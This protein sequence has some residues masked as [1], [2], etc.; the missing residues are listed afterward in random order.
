MKRKVNLLILLVVAVLVLSLA[1]VACS[2]KIDRSKAPDDIGVTDP[3]ASVIEKASETDENL[4]LRFVF[5]KYMSSVFTAIPIDVFD[6]E[7]P[8]FNIGDFIKY[9]VIYSVSGAPFDNKLL[10]LK[11][12]DISEVDGVTVNQLDKLKV[13]GKHIVKVSIPRVDKDP[14]IGS[15]TLN[16]AARSSDIQFVKLSFNLN[17]GTAYFGNKSSNGRQVIELPN[18]SK[19]TWNDFIRTFLMKK[20]GYVID[21]IESTTGKKFDA[22]N[23]DINENPVVFDE[24]V[25]FNV[26]WTANIVNVTF[27]PKKPADA[28]D[29][30]PNADQVVASVT[31]P[32][33]VVMDKGTIERPDSE[34]VNSYYG[35]NFAGW[36]Y[37]DPDEGNAEKLWLFTQTVGRRD[38]ALYGKWVPRYYSIEIYTMGGSFDPNAQGLTKE[39]IANGNYSYAEADVTFDL[40]EPFAP[41]KITFSGFKYNSQL[42]KYIAVIKLEKDS[43]KTVT[44]QISKLLTIMQ[45]AGGKFNANGIFRDEIHTDEIKGDDPITKDETSYIKWTM[46]DEVKQN[47]EELSDYYINYAF[48]DGIRLKADG[49]LSIDRLYDASIN[50][51]VVP[52]GLIWT[53][54]QYRP[55]TEIGDRSFMSA[56][57]LVTL[58]LKDAENLT[59]INTRAFNYCQHLKEVILPTNNHIVEIGED[60]FMSTIWESNQS[61]LIIIGTAIYK[62]VGTNV[63]S[64]TEIDFGDVPAL[65][66]LGDTKEYNISAGCFSLATSLQRIT[67]TDNI[68]YIHNYAFRGLKVL[69]E[70]VVGSDSKLYYVG[71]DAFYGCDNYILDY[72]AKNDN[73]NVRDG[74]IVLGKVFYR[75]IN[76]NAESYEIKSY[77]EHIAPSAFLGCSKLRAVTFEDDTKIKTIGKDAFIDTLWIQGVNDDAYTKDGFTIVNGILAAVYSQDFKVKDLLLPAGVKHITEYAFGSFS[78]Y[79]ETVTLNGDIEH[80]DDFAFAGASSLKSIVFRETEISGGVIVNCPTISKNAFANSKGVL[81]SGVKLYFTSEVVDR[82]TKQECAEVRPDWY[83]LR[84]LHEEIFAV[85]TI[86]GVWI[87]PAKVPNKFVM[88]SDVANLLENVYNDTYEGGKKLVREGLVV[89]SSSGITSYYPL[90]EDDIDLAPI[91][92]TAD[93]EYHILKFKYLG[94]AEHCHNYANQEHTFKYVVQKGIKGAPDFENTLNGGVTYITGGTEYNFLDSTPITNEYTL[95]FLGYTSDE[96]TQC[97]IVGTM[98]DGDNKLVTKYAIVPVGKL[99]FAYWIEGFDGDLQ[100]KNVPTFYTSHTELDI[101][102]I[103]FH[104]INYSGTEKTIKVSS[105]TGYAPTVNKKSSVTFAVNFHG[106]GVYHISVP[107]E[108]VKSKYIRI[109]QK[110]SISIPLNG[111]PAT[112]LRNSYVYLVGQDG[113]EQKVLFNLN[114]FKLVSVD[115]EATTKLPT[116]KLGL[117]TMK[118][119]YTSEDTNGTIGDDDEIVF[120][121]VLEADSRVF[122]IEVTNELTRTAKVTGCT[123]K[124]AETLVIPDKYYVKKGDGTV[125]TYTVNE[126]GD[127][128]FASFTALK[129]VYLPI[130]LE[131]I[132]SNAF[133]GCMLLEEIYTATQSEYVISRIDDPYFKDERVTKTYRGSVEVTGL[134]FTIVPNTITVP[135]YLTWTEQNTEQGENYQ[136]EYS[137]NVEEEYVM[138]PAFK[139][140][141]F[142]KF[143]GTIWLYDNEYNRAYASAY[144]ANKTVEFYTSADNRIP[145][146]Q[147][148]FEFDKSKATIDDRYIVK[149]AKLLTLEDITYKGVEYKVNPNDY[150]D[151]V[152]TPSFNM[153]FKITVKNG[154]ETKMVEWMVNI[155]AYQMSAE[156]VALGYEV[157]DFVYDYTGVEVKVESNKLECPVTIILH[158]PNVDTAKDKEVDFVAVFVPEEGWEIQYFERE[159]D[160]ISATPAELKVADDFDGFVYLPDTIFN[161]VILTKGGVEY[162]DDTGNKKLTVYKSGITTLVST[163]DYVTDNLEYIGSTAFKDCLNLKH[164]V[165]GENSQL[166]DI[167]PMAFANSGLVGIDLSKTQ[168]VEINEQ[169]FKGCSALRSVD[170]PTTLTTI[171]NSAF[172]GSGLE[173]IDFTT[174]NVTSLGEQ[175]FAGCTNLETVTLSNKISSM[176]VGVFEGS[177]VVTAD[178]SALTMTALA[179]QTFEECEDLANVTLPATLTSIGR[180]AFADCARLASF[181]VPAGLTSI[182]TTAFKDCYRLVE[183]CNKSGLSLVAGSEANGGIALYALRIY[184]EGESKVVFD[185]TTGFVVYDE[186]VLVDYRG[187]AKVVEIPNGI[188]TINAYAFVGSENLNG[189]ILPT[190]L[191][192]IDEYAFDGCDNIAYVYY[193]GTQTQWS[194]VTIGSNNHPLTSA[195]TCYYSDSQPTDTSVKYWHY[196]VSG[197]PSVWIV[198]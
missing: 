74:A 85:E 169:T 45:K 79:I 147:S 184:T 26:I 23:N 108:G 66:M 126:I 82:F 1:L 100:D 28:I 115:N 24:S 170:L 41:N 161:Q 7:D 105:V 178:L 39:Q 166:A 20:A 109:R 93:G 187:N 145:A 152:V 53:D 16:L 189:V 64:V 119:R 141:L 9:Q 32:Q 58:N 183:I 180:S 86:E 129:T 17:G 62:F 167:M 46:K 49:S 60:A 177:G 48:K 136:R 171:C 75:L 168:L 149:Y 61:G 88:Y 97:R 96:K 165:F 14:L 120:A 125:I 134:L 144:L 160:Y 43:D 131:K 172:L 182:G 89:K 54:G 50:E 104:Y 34:K 174:T 156:D 194:A 80:I 176:G 128:A 142:D 196:D 84:Q 36:Y 181:E 154:D 111:D 83:E 6:L 11:L 68:S 87:N 118:V 155:G 162:L 198:Y 35:Y 42:D 158:N 190:S 47:D 21:Y 107:Y 121:V 110:D 179:D 133:A 56:K 106:I 76:Q 52:A 191:T 163:L 33:Q 114:T 123:A 117:H 197:E 146:D 195:T 150:G 175:A 38:I 90:K 186:N 40:T 70:I 132:G 51:I 63:G 44:I 143:K 29:K 15:F 130:T 37:K 69:D 5:T 78:R 122:K 173:S 124:E 101:K 31:Q 65:N 112:Y 10:S 91:S 127:N 102:N 3:D 18:D 135:E 159:T 55:I 72:K 8:E 30:V 77:I 98:R 59:C 99:D 92:E 151:I 193:K 185:E 81:L 13:A 103:V 157:Q 57:S 67:L 12:E 4:M 188:V 192:E 139:A 138:R 140:D 94:S 73:H 164:I 71:E 19:F 25:D 137:Y 95:E 116:N 2:R 27:D 148:R 153:P 22:K 113:R